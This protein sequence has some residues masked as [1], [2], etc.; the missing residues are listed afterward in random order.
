MKVGLFFGAGA[1][2]DYGM[3]LGGRFALEIFRQDAT[4]DKALLEA[5][6]AAVDPRSIY[7]NTWLPEKYFQQS[8]WKFGKREFSALVESTIEHR[9]RDL[10]DFL[11]SFDRRAARVLAG[12]QLSRERFQQAVE[13]LSGYKFGQ[14][15]YGNVVELNDALS[16]DVSLF[17]SEYFSAFLSVLE[18]VDD[19]RARPLQRLVLAFVQLLV[20]VHGHRLVDS[21]SHQLFTRA[22]DELSFLQDTPNMFRLE[23]SEVGKS[24]L[25]L[26]L[27]APSFRVSDVSTN[28]EVVTGF[29]RELLTELIASCLDYRKL[30][31]E[32]FHYLFSPRAH[33]AKFTRIATFLLTVRRYIAE[34]VAPNEARIAEG[35]GYYH[36]LGRFADHGL[37]LAAVGTSNYNTFITDILARE[38]GEHP[39]VHHLNGGLADFYDPYLNKLVA[40][41][42]PD[43]LTR[44][45]RL[46]VP[47]MLTQSGTKPLTSVE[48]SERYVD[49]HRGFCDCDVVAVVGYGFNVDDSHINAIF[50]SLVERQTP[51]VVFEFCANGDLDAERDRRIRQGLRFERNA[52]VHLQPVDAERMCG[53][54]PW[55]ER[56][57]ELA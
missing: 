15:R 42:S 26:V 33:W 47:F 38:L 8:L 51:L 25:E 21:L 48:M 40:L 1:E 12:S 30:I 11:G 56:L 37:E 36:D 13:E 54:R 27:D 19:G 2:V 43:D 10:L 57:S 44:T 53:G 23:L 16:D 18:A 32:Y 35:P 24:S 6:L 14:R 5:Q 4:P 55:Y 49:L 50:R 20:A 41:D 7:A 46:L 29:A 28:I 52:P 39:D 9:R 22:P 34:Q 17:S 45:E 3:P 31:D